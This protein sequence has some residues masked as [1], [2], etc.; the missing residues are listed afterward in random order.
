MTGCKKGNG[1][2]CEKYEGR[3]LALGGSWSST[4]FEFDRTHEIIQ[5][6]KQDETKFKKASIMNKLKDYAAFKE[7]K[8]IQSATRSFLIWKNKHANEDKQM[9]QNSKLLLF[10]FASMLLTCQ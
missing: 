4:A 8:L 5:N 6:S 2:Y 10:L 3:T 1:W 9:S 7:L